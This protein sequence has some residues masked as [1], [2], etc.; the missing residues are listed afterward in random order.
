MEVAK[1]E[2]MKKTI[3]LRSQRHELQ[4][5]RVV[6]MTSFPVLLIFVYLCKLNNEITLILNILTHSGLF[7][8]KSCLHWLHIKKLRIQT[9][10]MK[11]MRHSM[12]TSLIN[13]C[14]GQTNNFFQVLCCIYYWTHIP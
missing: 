9:V 4:T 8:I 10:I 2:N 11:S 3:N 6:Y 13:L 7:R 12:Y 5:V 1:P 14:K